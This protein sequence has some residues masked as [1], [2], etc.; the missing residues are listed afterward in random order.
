M[1]EASGKGEKRERQRE[2]Q[3][4][5]FEISLTFSCFR[6]ATS[7][8]RFVL[9][10]RLLSTSPTDHLSFLLFLT[11]LSGIHERLTLLFLV[12]EVSTT[13]E[14]RENIK[15]VSQEESHEIEFCFFF[16]FTYYLSFIYT[17]S[18]VLYDFL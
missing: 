14:G 13:F 16:N 10:L 6:A 11:M 1:A 8:W 15:A 5:E 18:I 4:M 7:I 3:N 2:M 12:Q 9:F 17:F